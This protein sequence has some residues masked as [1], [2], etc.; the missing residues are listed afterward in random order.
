MQSQEPS[1]LLKGEQQV[2]IKKWLRNLWS[3]AARSKV[4]ANRRREKRNRMRK[5]ERARWNKQE[6]ST[7]RTT[8]VTSLTVNYTPLDFEACNKLLQSDL[9]QQ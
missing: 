9:S 4:E 7:R 5:I 2:N 8:W 3:A 1:K 6:L